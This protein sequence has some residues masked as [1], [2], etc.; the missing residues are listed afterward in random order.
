MLYNLFI[1][2]S[3]SY[4]DQYERLINLL[5]SASNFPY[6]DYSVPKNDPIHGCKYDYQLREAIKRQMQP[7]SCVL[8]LAGLYSSYS[9]WINI[10]IDLAKEMNKRIVAIE[11]F[12]SLH[13]SAVVKNN[14]DVVVSW[15]TTS[16]IRGIRGY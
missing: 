15:N 3:W 11:P 9:R 8:I 14:A 12:G 1:S 13:A 16:I 10:E 6:K 2:H 4:S 5:N 7:A